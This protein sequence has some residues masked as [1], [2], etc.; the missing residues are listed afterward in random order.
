[1]IKVLVFGTF[2]GL[3]EGHR[4]FLNE[5]KKLGDYLIVAVAHDSAV[6]LFKN[7]AP[8][9]D[10]G[11]RVSAILSENLADE[12][13]IGDEEQGSWEVLKKH[14]PDIVAVGHDQHELRSSLE[15]LQKEFGI[16]L[17]DISLLPREL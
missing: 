17:V 16:E 8:R 14:T 5:A 11:A 4:Y 1:M 10:A 3:H 9:Q 6:N 13:V 15:S 7:R 12:V 2:D